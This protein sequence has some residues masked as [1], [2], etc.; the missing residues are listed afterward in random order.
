MLDLLRILAAFLLVGLNAFF[1]AT[2]FAITRVRAGQIADLEREGRPGARAARHAVEHLDAYLAACQLG[3]TVASIGLGALAEPA[4]HHVLEP[5]LGAFSESA[6]VA[7]S[8]VLA[9]AIVT[10]LHVVLGE[11]APKSLAIARTTR[12][13]LV[14]APPMR[15][16]YLI[17]RPLVDGF[18]WLGNLVLRPFGIPPAREVGHAPHT[19]QELRLLLQQSVAEG[20]IDTYERDWAENV[21]L[22]G[23]MRAR[24]VMVP[25]GEIDHL[26]AGET[27]E[28]A[29]HRAVASLHTRLPLCETEGALDEPIG[30]VNSKELLRLAL[31]G[32]ETDLVELAR[33]LSRVSESMLVDEVLREL[34]SRR[35]HMALVADEFGTTVG[36]VT[37]DDIIEEIVGELED[38]EEGEP[39]ESLRREDGWLVVRGDT[40]VG[41]VE[42]ELG[43][44][45]VDGGEATIGGHV[46]EMLGRVPDPGEQLVL[47]GHDLVI[48]AVDE[49][50]IDELR[51]R[52]EPWDP[53]A[54]SVS[55]RD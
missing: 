54:E 52:L 2:E 18:N 30:V 41:D 10:L 27:I 49:A 9:F 48:E 3:I 45:I 15:V 46:V 12:T 37:L 19:E 32:V 1:V 14:V 5:L 53:G 28:Q 21:F 13:V 25:R 16:F 43:I 23:D 34:R 38:E 6:A 51:L 20:L 44:E 31:D 26:V 4:F 11:L 40:P 17:T 7:L 8:L 22:F 35:Q 24:Q 29:T 36:L 50:R 47:L 33:P 39:P 55:R 42:D